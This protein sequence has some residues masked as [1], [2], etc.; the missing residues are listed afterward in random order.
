MVFLKYLQSQIRGK[1]AT[2][3][4]DQNKIRNI[5]MGDDWNNLTTSYDL[6]MW[7]LQNTPHQDKTVEYAQDLEKIHHELNY[8]HTRS[9]EFYFLGLLIMTF[10]SNNS[11]S[12]ILLFV[13]IV[14]LRNLM[15]FT[16]LFYTFY[17]FYEVPTHY[18]W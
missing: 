13:K 15:I 12:Q 14:L 4:I 18:D 8:L 2:Q 16:G 3:K 5:K 10:F 1:L 9:K 17:T 6:R 7:Y 11:D